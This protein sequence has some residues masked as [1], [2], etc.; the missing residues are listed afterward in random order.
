MTTTTTMSEKV[1]PADHGGTA[2]TAGGTLA[3]SDC[4]LPD[5]PAL[6]RV[7]A[8]VTTRAGGTSLPP[9]GSPGNGDGGEGDHAGSGSARPG[10][11]NLGAHTGDDPAAVAVNRDRLCRLIQAQPAWLN[12]IHGSEV[13]LAE[14]ALRALRSGNGPWTADASATAQP[15]I[16]CVVMVADCLPVLLADRLGRAVGAAHAGWRGLV[17]GVLERAAGKVA[18]LA[19]PQ[20]ELQAYLGPCIG[21]RVFEVGAEVRDA[22][23]AAAAADERDATSAAFATHAVPGK[24]WADLPAL[25]RLRLARVGV[26]HTAGGAHCTVTENHRFYSYRRERTT[27]RFAGLIWLDA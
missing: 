20:A 5:W 9:F 12:Q 8:L 24:Y 4:L 27:G 14:D 22:F 16:A 17:G 15:G 18:T 2:K 11:L 19:G 7:K 10:G 3:W 1:E 26:R 23:V 21:P 25:A 13:V 6:P